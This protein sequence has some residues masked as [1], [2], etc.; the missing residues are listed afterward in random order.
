[1][2]PY[3]I[4][5][6]Y[7]RVTVFLRHLKRDWF[8][9]LQPLEAQFALA[10]ADTPFDKRTT[11]TYHQIH[12][13][14]CWGHTWQTGWFHFTGTMPVCSTESCVPVIRINT[15]SEA[16]LFSP[17]GKALTGLTSFCWFEND[18]VRE[19][20]FPPSD[21]LAGSPLDYWCAV[22]AN[23][24][25]GLTVDYDPPYSA[26]ENGMFDAYFKM[27][28]AGWLR[29]EV[30]A[31]SLDLE[32]LYSLVMTFPE[33]DYRRK[34][35]ARAFDAAETAYA[36]DPANATAAR[37]CLAPLLA[38]PAYASSM[39]VTA[40]GHSHID[41]AYMWPVREAIHK[42]A[43][44]YST[45]LDLLEACPD[46]VFGASQPQHYQFIKER[47]PEIYARIKE[48]VAQGRWEPQG[49][50]W[51]EA[52]VNMPDGESLVRQFLH[53]KNFFRDEFG[54]EVRN[55]WLPDVFGYTGAL[56]QIMML[57]RCESFVSVKLAF[58]EFD[59]HPYH[60]FRWRGIDGTEVL[61]HLPPEGMYSSQLKPKTLCQAQNDY[62]EGAECREF[63]SLFGLGDGGGGACRDDLEA[64]RRL[65]N[66][67]GAP[68]VHFGAAQPQLERLMAHW[69]ELPAWDGELYY[70]RHRGT[71]TAIAHGKRGN[72]KNEQL[73]AAT[74]YLCST[75]L[76]GSQY[77]IALLDK[78]WKLLL[79]HQFHD[80]MAGSS[81]D[82]TY[83]EV[84]R[85]YGIIRKLCTQATTAATDKL[86]IDAGAVTLVNT[87]NTDWHG[88]LAFPPKDG[89]V[90][91]STMH[92]SDGAQLVEVRMPPPL[93][94]GS[95]GCQHACSRCAGAS[96]SRYICTGK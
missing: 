47:Y 66:L 39:M 22:T 24:L 88:L 45:Q 23:K 6:A 13:G 83:Q 75:L 4:Q 34:E 93:Q 20:Y 85:D 42:C 56:P 60:T 35:F 21:T 11:L 68:R 18:F 96:N 32:C 67:E 79:L 62:A 87:L 82:E 16:L 58:A 17:T 92:T 90:L 28:E 72:R 29:T 49:G 69:E 64:G 77:P 7:E 33:N 78:A 76:A 26:E 94:R 57:A 46:Y 50:M 19:E 81:L 36:D 15:G 89:C 8:C 38:R 95:K 25:A 14:K 30:K 86:P 12:P 63:L 71:T 51:V 91:E 2:Q 5:R 73:L 54:I 10:N 40:V 70:E 48:A 52:D 55:L 43:R 1:M 3:H 65:A 61:A 31:L 74:E 27:A 80:T 37:A 53:G 41:T 9:G 84:E 59:R 44:T